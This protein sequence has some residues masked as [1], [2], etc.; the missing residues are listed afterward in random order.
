M[1]HEREWE[2]WRGEALGTLGEIIA[3]LSTVLNTSEVAIEQSRHYGT[4]LL[5]HSIECARAIRLC[6]RNNLPGPAGAL[7]R[8][9]YE[10]ALRG[11]IIVHEM[12][13]KELNELLVGTQEWLQLKQSKQ[14][15]PRMWKESRMGPVGMKHQGGGSSNAVGV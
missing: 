13:L 15:L 8:A 11:H 14:S 2:E 1:T 12:D 3:W 4:A 10:G 5:A 7:A 6:I 9:Q